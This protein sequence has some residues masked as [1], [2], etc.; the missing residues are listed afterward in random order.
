MTISFKKRLIIYALCFS[1][2]YAAAPWI[3][4]K[5]DYYIRLNRRIISILYDYYRLRSS[6]LVN[7]AMLDSKIKQGLPQWAKAQI[8]EDLK[9]YK[10]FKKSDL[11]Y[12]KKSNAL[13]KYSIKSKKLTVSCGKNSSKNTSIELTKYYMKYMFDLL[14]F[15]VREQYIPDTEFILGI[16]D[17]FPIREE[18]KFPVFVFAK[19]LDSRFEK[20]LVLVPDWM[21]LMD[22][23]SLRT[24]IAEASKRFPWALKK[25]MFFWRSSILTFPRQLLASWTLE[26]PD[27]IDAKFLNKN[28][29]VSFV[30]PADHLQ[31]KYLISIDGLRCSWTRLVWH[32]HS[33]SLTFKYQS[34]QEQWFYKG[35]KPYRDYIPFTDKESLL[36]GYQWAE[37]HPQ[38][39]QQMIKSSTTFVEDNLSIEDMYHYFIVLLQEYTK[40][41]EE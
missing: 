7:K 11:D 40:K 17:F 37:T 25:P 28:E 14:S 26:N 20:N 3:L 41:L 32:L 22:A 24:E 9:H 5:A 34:N 2:F 15:L 10:A 6:Q 39:V 27:L 18:V 35:I 13:C 33:N 12:Y 30:K 23:S 19:D 16:T 4:L 8:Q 29:G 1:A 36:A 38:E 21:N 31:Y